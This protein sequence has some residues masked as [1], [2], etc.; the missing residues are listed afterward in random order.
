MFHLG[1]LLRAQ[2]VIAKAR[3]LHSAYVRLKLLFHLFLNLVLLAELGTE[4]RSRGT[5]RNGTEERV[6]PLLFSIFI[7]YL[8]DG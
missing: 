8:F 6:T 1:I 7:I 2:Y 4:R 5:E 3:R